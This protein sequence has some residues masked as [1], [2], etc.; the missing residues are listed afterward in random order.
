MNGLNEVVE[1]IVN[2]HEDC[3]VAEPLKV[4]TRAGQAFLCA[5]DA[6]LAL[7]EVHDALL[8]GFEIHAA[9]DVH[10]LRDG[11]FRALRS[12]S[13]SCQTTKCSSTGASAMMRATSAARMSMLSRFSLAASCKPIAASWPSFIWPS[14]SNSAGRSRLFSL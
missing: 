3:P 1:L 5:E 14:A 9:V 6:G 12:S 10:H 2:T 11:F 7:C 13:K 4:A 8:A